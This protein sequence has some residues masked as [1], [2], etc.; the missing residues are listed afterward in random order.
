MSDIQVRSTPLP[1]I[2]A[3]FDV[4]LSKHNYHKLLQS[5]SSITVTR[6]NVGEDL[7]KEGREILRILEDEKDRQAAEPL[8]WHRNIMQV[9]KEAKEPIEEQVN[10]ILAQKK[11][12][13]LKLR[14]EQEAQFAE[15]E[16]ISRAKSAIIS[17][18]N[19]I[20]TKIAA[21]KTD[22]E[23]VEIEKAIG[24]EKTKKYLYQEFLPELIAQ[25]DNLRPKIKEQ[26]EAIRLLNEIKKQEA[27]AA[28]ANDIDTITSIKEKKDRISE[29]INERAIRIHEAAFE[30]A[31]SIEVVVPEIAESVPSGR[32]KWRF[33]VDDIK[34]LQKKMPHMVLVVPNEEAIKNHLDTLKR[35]GSL[36]GKDEFKWNG[37]TFYNDKSFTK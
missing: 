31:S 36:V 2:K 12:L 5:L 21:A 27:E 29:E 15:Q 14:R 9:Y 17:F 34:L 28:A 10:R 4:E 13:A 7:T 3:S 35:D 20:A 32:S 24:I 23:I 18:C 26:K 19:G 37:I 8:R 22:K 11:E 30:Q 16:R 25:V 6:D 1:V 33:R